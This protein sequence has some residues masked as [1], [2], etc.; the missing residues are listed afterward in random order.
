MVRP[1]V[2]RAKISGYDGVVWLRFLAVTRCG[3][4]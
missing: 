4:A 2:K 1:R 3:K